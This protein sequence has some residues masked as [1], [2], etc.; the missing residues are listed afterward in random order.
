MHWA[1]WSQPP[2]S[3]RHSLI[4]CIH[5]D[6]VIKKIVLLKTFSDI[7]LTVEAIPSEALPTDA[8]IRPIGVFALSKGVTVVEIQQ[9][10]VIISASLLQAVVYW[11]A[12][13]TDTVVGPEHVD[14]FPIFTN[15]NKVNAS[16]RSKCWVKDRISLHQDWWCIRRD[17]GMRWHQV[18]SSD[19]RYKHRKRIPGCCDTDLRYRYCP[20]EKRKKIIDQC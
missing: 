16:S 4:S 5:W 20:A 19:L 1:S 10:F 15:L 11:E 17:P 8:V 14:T 6:S 18:P 2:L 9:T 13:I 3:L 12:V 7:Y